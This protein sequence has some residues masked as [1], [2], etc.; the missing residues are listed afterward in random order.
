VTGTHRQVPLVRPVMGDEEAEAAGRVI[1][2][3]WITQGPEVAAFE[4]EFAT[5]VGAGHACA[6]SNCTTALHLALLVVGVAAGDEV[7]TVSHSY[8]A[9]A[10]AVTYCGATPVFVDVE[11]VTRN[12]DPALVE[13]AIGPRTRAILAVH[14]IGMPCDMAALV[15][16]GRRH[17][18]PVIEDAAC[19]VG[20][21]IRW[22]DDWQRI[23]R[24]HGTIACFSFHPRKVM[25]TGDGGMIT[26]DDADLAARCR[27]LRQ[28]G[29]SVNDRVR[30]SSNT[31]VFED[32]SI[33]GFNY[34]MTDIQAAVG[35]VQLGRLPSI[36]ARRREVADRYRELL[37]DLDGLALPVEPSWCRSNWQ[38]YTVGLP[39]GVDQRAFMQGMLDRGIAT[40]RGIMCAHRE[41]PYL[42]S[43]RS[44]LPWS[45]WAQD[46]FVVLPLYP[47]MDDDDLAAVAESTN[48]VLAT[49]R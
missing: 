46:R 16:I 39:D 42:G 26:T 13:A 33:I 36:V 4:Q 9:T 34:R 7:I 10:N 44:P 17:G 32:H 1:R 5:F 30:H 24:P 37:D 14:Q 18:L 8:V 20:S 49:L 21:E 41:Q 25:S 35:R 23:G 2:S 19:A 48:E 22:G 11:P 31:V 28:H 38:S 6:V 40:R 47:S 3:G 45:E 27:L 15:E 29:M 12:I 43:E